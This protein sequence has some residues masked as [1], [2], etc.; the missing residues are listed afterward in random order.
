MKE[1]K[2]QQV[3]Y[4]ESRFLKKDSDREHY[5]IVV[6]DM[7]VGYDDGQEKKGV[8]IITTHTKEKE[9]D[10]EAINGTGSYVVLDPKEYPELSHQSIVSAQIYEE[11]SICLKEEDRKI[12]VSE[13]VLAKIKEAAKK[14]K[15]NKGRIKRL[16]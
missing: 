8:V 1:Y 2:A 10:Y 4:Y 5:H 3:Y 15:N 7:A 6:V 14:H 9:E 16:L 13:E 12:D 11:D